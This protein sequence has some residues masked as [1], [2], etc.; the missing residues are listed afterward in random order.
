MSTNL[1]GLIGKLN[2]TTRNALEAAAGFCLARTHYDIEVEHF[3]LKLL[4]VADSDLPRILKQFGV[5][6][7]RL[8]SDLT[9][10]LDKLKSG[11]ARTPA[12]APTL[13]QMLSEAW[14][15][16]SLDFGA[17]QV[18]SGFCILAIATT[19]DLSR[20]LREVTREF[21]KINAETL[22]KD[23][24][25]IVAGSPED[26]ETDA[27]RFDGYAW[28]CAGCRTGR[29]KNAESRSIHTGPDGQRQ[30]RK[31]GRRAGPRPRNPPNH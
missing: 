11:N 26:R 6:S 21:Q 9:R 1:K 24:W 7:S 31:A 5:D 20:L 29:R 10:S 12:F 2:D 16:G 3:L 23:F 13:T 30:G 17:A 27:G 25:N 22:H 8:S 19:P 4:D 18:R 28:S 14:T 15:T